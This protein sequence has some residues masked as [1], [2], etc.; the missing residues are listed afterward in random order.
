ML[1]SAEGAGKTT[2][3]GMLA[4]LAIFRA[5][6]DC[7]PGAL[8]A[9]APTSKR[10]GTLQKAVAGL[11][12]V[13][14]SRDQRPS[15]WGTYFVD[16]GDLVTVSGHTIQFRSTKVQSADA[17]SPIQGWNWGLGCLCDEQQDQLHAYSDIVARLRSGENAPIVATA[18]AKDSPAWRTWRDGLSENW[19]IERLQYTDTPFVHDS[20]WKLLKTECSDREWRRRGLAQDVGPER[21]VYTSWDRE[22]NLR[23]IPRIGARD[24]TSEVLG[25]HAGN[26]SVLVGF[27]PGLSVNTS[28][29]LK[30][31]RTRGSREHEWF[32]VDEVITNG[33]TQGHIRALLE[34]LRTKWHCNLVDDSGAPIYGSDIAHVRADPYG[35]TADGTHRTVYT[36]FRD[37]GLSIRAAAYNSKTAK[38]AKVPKEAGIEMVC[39]LLCNV[40][41]V[42]RLFVAVDENGTPS[43][44]K[45]LESIEL[46]ERGLDGKAE[47]AKKGTSKDLSHYTAAVRYALWIFEKPR[48]GRAA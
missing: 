13:D 22:Q 34:R 6:R 10:L 32:I 25:P 23:P 30:A 31:Y 47:T 14:S 9:T 1:Y 33:T 29:L 44:K 18:T 16:A 35:D 27:D 37:A 36:Q 17:G 15:S 40:N 5:T 20:H 8:G 3:M 48:I 11:G 46:S 24:V 2:L 39:R 43:A 26:A 41:S 28:V 42:R 4:W 19:S 38:P 12:P 21:M 7:V 45:T